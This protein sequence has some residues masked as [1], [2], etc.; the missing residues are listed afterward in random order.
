MHE[1]AI[2]EGVLAVALDHARG[3]PVKRVH[4]R[5]GHLRQVVPSALLFSFELVARDTPADG[6]VLEIDEVPAAGTCRRCGAES[7]LPAFPFACGACGAFDVRITR[8][9]ELQVEWLEVDE[10]EAEIG[11]GHDRNTARM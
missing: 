11:V 10:E 1:L 8:G 2:A 5:V 4:L 7:D 9:E 6:A 3:R